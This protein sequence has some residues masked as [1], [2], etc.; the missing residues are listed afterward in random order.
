MALARFSIIVAVDGGNGIAKKGDIPWTSSEDMKFFRGTTIGKGKN[1]V[2][3]GRITYESIPETRRP[4]ANRKCVVISRTWKQEDH[5][6]IGVYPSLIDALAGIGALTA[7]HDEVFIA[8]GEQLYSEAIK[9]FMYLCNKIY[10][11]KFKTDYG[12]DQFFPY[13]TIKDIPQAADPVKTRDYIRYTFI[14]KFEHDEYQYLNLLKEVA[15]TGEAKPDRTGVGTRSIFG[16]HMVFDIRDRIPVL[17]T[18]R[19]F[20]EVIIKELLFFISGKTDTRILSSQGVKIWEGNTKEKVLKELGLPWN[21]GDFGP[22][23]SHQ[24][25]HYGAEYTGCDTDYTGKGLDQLQNLIDGLRNDPHSRRHIITAWNPS[26][27][28]QMALAPCHLL[29]QFNV[30]GDGRWLD[31][32]LYQRSGDL[33]LGVPFNITS[34]ALLTTMIGHVTGL[35]PRKFIHT[36]GDAHIYNNHGEQ[37]K[38]QLGRCPR[39]FPRLSFRE[40]TRIHEIEDFTSNSFIIEGYSSWPTISAEMAV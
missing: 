6:E 26:Q 23:Y 4:L 38:R 19:I 5:P 40:A 36:I 29:A 18:K 28:S 35:R 39:P 2:V 31:C 8:G 37:V 32:Q 21:E 7:G 13:D 9:D 33:F 34:Y 12:C 30:S 1:V 14:P 17:T 20:Y 22:G 16:A 27:I 15:Q 10:V 11:T 25:R 24:W 3:M